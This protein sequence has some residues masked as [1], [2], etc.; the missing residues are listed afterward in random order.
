[1]LIA[2]LVIAMIRRLF[3]CLLLLVPAAGLA[4]LFVSLIDAASL[5][6]AGSIEPLTSQVEAQ[7]AARSLL[8]NERNERNLH[9]AEVAIAD[10]CDGRPVRVSAV[11]TDDTASVA[12]GERSLVVAIGIDRRPEDPSYCPLDWPEPGERW[13]IEATVRGL[14]IM[15]QAATSFGDGAE[16]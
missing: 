8:H 11:Y 2:C 5:F 9:E 3:S 16:F 1:M 4:L 13:E 15:R 10:F 7:M 12:F 6:H 14:A